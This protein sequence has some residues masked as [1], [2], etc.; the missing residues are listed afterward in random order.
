MNSLQDQ[1]FPVFPGIGFLP[2]HSL[3]QHFE[4]VSILIAS[5]VNIYVG[6]H[7]CLSYLL[8]YCTLLKVLEWVGA[9]TY[10]QRTEKAD[11]RLQP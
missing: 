5:I 3:N 4:C 1:S 7:V 10:R 11:Y 2:C 8:E 9:S 6:R